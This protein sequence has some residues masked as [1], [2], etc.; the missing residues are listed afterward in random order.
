MNNKVTVL[1]FWPWQT[2]YWSFILIILV[3]IIIG[4]SVLKRFALKDVC[5]KAA[6][7]IFILRTLGMISPLSFLIPGCNNI[8]LAGVTTSYNEM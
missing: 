5:K 7:L 1:H 6:L 3:G 2:S 8:N 4:S